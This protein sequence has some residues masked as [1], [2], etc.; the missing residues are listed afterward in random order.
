MARTKPHGKKAEEAETLDWITELKQSIER[1]QN[2]RPHPACSW[3]E[4]FPAPGK[5]RKVSPLCPPS[6]KEPPPK[7]RTERR[8]ILGVDRPDQPAPRRRFERD[9]NESTSTPLQKAVRRMR[10][11]PTDKTIRRVLDSAAEAILSGSNEDALAEVHWDVVDASAQVLDSRVQEAVRNPRAINVQRLL[12]SWGNYQLVGGEDGDIIYGALEAAEKV[13][14]RLARDAEYR[15]RND[16]SEEN[17]ALAMDLVATGQLIGVEGPL[18]LSQVLA[19]FHEV[20]GREHTIRAGDTLSGLSERYYG[21]PG[22][23]DQIYLANSQVLHKSASPDLL[24][25]GVV[26]TIP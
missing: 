24:P 13:C 4:A 17:W 19:G 25:Q 3:S 9:A 8:R 21:R 23:W 5:R 11:N 10:A 1:S 22:Y 15:F 26:L 18:E 20:G 16:P 14:R 12:D 7:E 2:R 6:I